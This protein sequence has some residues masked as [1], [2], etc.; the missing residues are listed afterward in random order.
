MNR[1]LPYILLALFFGCDSSDG[2]RVEPAL[3]QENEIRMPVILGDA[4]YVG[5]CGSEN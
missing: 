2:Q 3:K 5:N 1:F 4:R